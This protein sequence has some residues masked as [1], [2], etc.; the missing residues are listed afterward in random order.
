MSPARRWVADTAELLGITAADISGVADLTPWRHNIT[1]LLGP[2]D[3]I[4]GGGTLAV[5]LINGIYAGVAYLS[6]GALNDEVD[7]DVPLSAGTWA[8]D[9]MYQKNTSN[10]IFTVKVDGVTAGTIDCYAAASYNNVATIADIAV[11]VTGKKRIGFVMASKNAAATAYYFG[12]QH[13]VMR[14]TA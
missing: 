11:A 14:R 3:N 8:I 13:I 4:V 5:A 7:W 1:P 2:P 9:V 10:G 6:T 12:L